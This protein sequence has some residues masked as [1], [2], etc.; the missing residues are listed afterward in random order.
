M[1]QF[2]L[3]CPHLVDRV[4]ELLFI[5]FNSIDPLFT[6]EFKR[7]AQEGFLPLFFLFQFL[8]DGWRHGLVIRCRQARLTIK[9]RLSGDWLI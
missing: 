6:D 3:L 9:A 7:L 1:N 2:Q 8:V 4:I 5:V